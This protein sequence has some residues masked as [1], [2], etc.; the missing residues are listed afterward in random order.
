M[1]PI[2]IIGIAGGGAGGAVGLTTLV[3]WLLQRQ[4]TQLDARETAF[5]NRIKKLEADVGH[6]VTANATLATEIRHVAD[7]LTELRA[8]AIELR[9]SV[10]TTRDKQGEFYRGELRAAVDNFRA[11]INA[12]EARVNRPAPRRR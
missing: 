12:L 1:T 9:A 8:T 11:E 10:E 4:V 2:D 7:K 3:K 6:L 5:D